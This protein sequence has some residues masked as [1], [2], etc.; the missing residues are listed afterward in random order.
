MNSTARSPASTPRSRQR[1]GPGNRVAQPQ[2]LALVELDPR[3]VVNGVVVAAGFK[4]DDVAAVGKM[5]ETC[6]YC[7]GLPLQLVLRHAHVIRS[8]LVCKTCTRCF[9]AV[10]PD[11]S[12]ALTIPAGLSID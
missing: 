2:G 10:Y 6:P 11:G 1:A 5:R 12:S 8:H 9:D 7:G 3:Q 4:A